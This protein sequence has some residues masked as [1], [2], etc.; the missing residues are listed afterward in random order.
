MNKDKQIDLIEQ[1]MKKAYLDGGNTPVIPEIWQG[2]VMAAV[3]R[4]PQVELKEIERT[5]RTLLHVSWIAAGI[6][7]VLVLVFGLFFTNNTN[8]GSIE[9]DLQNFYVDNSMTDMLKVISQ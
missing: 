5:E 8:D 1:A 6:A 7:A 4:V 2:A 3:K 9:K